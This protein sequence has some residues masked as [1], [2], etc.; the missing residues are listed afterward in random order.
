MD[1]KPKNPN[2]IEKALDILQVFLPDNLELGTSQVSEK[3]G[4]HKATASRIL[5][6]LTQRGF[7]Q[8]NPDT[9]KFSLGRKALLLGRSVISSLQTGIVSIAKPHIDSLRTKLDETVALEQ[10]IGNTTVLVYIA[11]GRQ[12]HR[13][14]GGLGDR[15][16][17]NAAA[18]AKAILAYSDHGFVRSLLDDNAGFESL[19]PYTITDLNTL[20][21]Q[22]RDVRINGFSFDKEEIDIGI[23]A[24]GVPIFNHD[25]LPVAALAV[26]GPAHRVNLDRAD[27]IVG[28]AMETARKISALL[29]QP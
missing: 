17:I 16:P 25:N 15:V 27:A 12:R 14:A 19:T 4:L 6:L 1:S 24:F 5:L 3:L 21:R 20:I 13:M 8:Q 18:G 28:P 2:A 9:K 7:L 23:N 22:L 10:L 26:I 29:L 11:E